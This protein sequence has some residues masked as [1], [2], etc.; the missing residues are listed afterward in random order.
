M[1]E[2]KKIDREY[3]PTLTFS[4]KVQVRKSN[5]NGYGVFAVSNIS[6]DQIIEQSPFIISGIRSK[7]LVQKNLRKFLWP[8]PC[9]CEECKYRG[10]PF[11][12]SSGFVQL[13]NH[14]TEPNVRIQFDTKT[15]IVTITTIKN[16]KK[17]EELLINYGPNYNL[18]E[19]F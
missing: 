12:I 18:F 8:L 1:E 7:D 17:D 15:R 14:S 6:S 10:R 13:Y 9:N 11:T 19:D 4:K 16:V 2:N 5:L 3:L